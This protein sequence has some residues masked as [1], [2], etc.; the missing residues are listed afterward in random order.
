MQLWDI[1][2]SC[3]EWYKEAAD[4]ES[5]IRLK[6]TLKCLV[7]SCITQ[8]QVFANYISWQLLLLLLN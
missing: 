3:G 2:A 8:Q 1:P 4:K 7:F 6:K 5:D